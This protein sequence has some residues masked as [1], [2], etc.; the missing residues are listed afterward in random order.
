MQTLTDRVE[1]LLTTNAGQWVNARDIA[2]VGGFA[3]WRT[4]VSDL[5]RQRGWTIENRWRTFT[6]HGRRYRV[7]E[8]RLVK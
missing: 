2:S 7:S 6:D 3:G 5:R 1:D 8:Y 4:R